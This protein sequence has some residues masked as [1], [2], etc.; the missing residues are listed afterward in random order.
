MKITSVTITLVFS[1]NCPKALFQSNLVRAVKFSLGI[2][3]AFCCKIKQLVLAGLA[4]MRHLQSTLATLFK[5]FPYCLNMSP[6]IFNNSFLSIPSFLGNPPTN[7]PKSRSLK[8]TS[9]SE[10]VWTE[11]IRGQAQSWISRDRPSRTLQHAG[12]SNRRRWMKV[13]SPRMLPLHN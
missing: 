7:I 10:P 1:A 4:T 6:L 13:L 2:F 9:G 3:W 5:A 12:M 8:R 11:R